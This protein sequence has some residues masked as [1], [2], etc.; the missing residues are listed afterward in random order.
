MM[1]LISDIFP[2]AWRA[3]VQIQ[4]Q[5]VKNET[6]KDLNRYGAEEIQESCNF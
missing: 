5:A 1:F 4:L 3:G 2:G 6:G